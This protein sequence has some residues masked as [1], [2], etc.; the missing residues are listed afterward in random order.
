MDIACWIAMVL[1]FLKAFLME[2]IE[3]LNVFFNDTIEEMFV[4]APA[5]AVITIDGSTFHPNVIISSRKADICLSC[6]LFFLV[7]T[8]HCNM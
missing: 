6:V 8:G 1:K 4:V 7:R 2:V 5:T 3:I